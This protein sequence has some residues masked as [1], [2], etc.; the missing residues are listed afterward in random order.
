[1]KASDTPKNIHRGCGIY[2]FSDD[3]SRVLLAQRGPAARHERFKW[4]GAGGEVEPDETFEQAAEREFLEEMGVPVTLG[5]VIAEFDEVED[6]L[7]TVWEAKIFSGTIS[8]TPTLPDP[9]KCTG[10]G[11]FTRAEVVA[12]AQNGILADYSVKDFQKIDWL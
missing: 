6:S 4:E 8:A 11:W 12:L 1:M 10:F 7:G 3:G 2:V 5:E 9:T